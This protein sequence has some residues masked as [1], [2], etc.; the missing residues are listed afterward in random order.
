MKTMGTR[1]VRLDTKLN[2]AIWGTGIRNVPRRI[3]VRN[4]SED[5]KDKLYTQVTYVPVTNFKGLETKVID[6]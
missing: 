3:R 2:E 5:A 4:D 1:D 6:E